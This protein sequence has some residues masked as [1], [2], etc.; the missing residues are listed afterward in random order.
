MKRSEIFFSV[1]LVPIDALMIVL[2]FLGAHILRQQTDVIYLL[3]MRSYLDFVLWT[4]PLW[5]VVFAMEGL[6]SMKAVRKGWD[7]VKGIF[8]ATSFGVLLVLAAIFL[9]KTEIGSRV[10]LLYAY[11]FTFIFIMLGR[12]LIRTLQK[13]LYHRQIGLHR[14]V[15]VGTNSTAQTLVNEFKRNPKSGFA[16]LGYIVPRDPKVRFIGKFLGKIQNID[17]I[18]DRVDFDDL[19]VIESQL[20]S[21]NLNKLILLAE[22]KGINVYLVPDILSARVKRFVFQD[23]GG[24]PLIKLKRT[25][26]DGWGRVAKR[27]IDIIGAVFGI[28][29][30]SPFMLSTALAVK[31]TSFGPI[32]YRNLRVGENGKRFEVLKFRSMKNELSTGKNYGGKKALAF[33]RQLIKTH[34][35]RSGAV[36]KIADDPRLTPIGGLI[37][38]WSLDE[39]PQFFNV[40]KGEMSL[41]GPRPHQPREVRKY[42]PWQKK[43]LTIKPGMT[44]LAQISGRSDLPFDEEA[45]I[46]IYYL[47]NWSLWLD[48][49]I[50]IRTFWVLLESRRRKAA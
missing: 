47:E 49:T 30:F 44:G 2:G 4:L 23:L 18:I 15:V 46:E 32:I 13:W 20:S 21:N 6:Y 25:P 26:L 16:Y 35:T 33:E 28:I 24:T 11:A 10:V 19:I 8:I 45:R 5:L 27:L 40:L 7:E 50:L 38:R 17:Q 37:R 43:L 22:Q 9:T 1:L 36:Y 3:P 48:I 29:I 42:K 39:L 41:V 14:V 34:N 12:W 31:L